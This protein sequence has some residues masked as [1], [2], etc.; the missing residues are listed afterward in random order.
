MPFPP[1]ALHAADA[2]NGHPGRSVS[3]TSEIGII[4]LGGLHSSHP[5]ME[6]ETH[7]VNHRTWR[8]LSR[9]VGERCKTQQLSLF[10]QLAGDDELR[11]LGESRSSAIRSVTVINQSSYERLRSKP[12]GPWL[13]G[14]WAVAHPVTVSLDQCKAM[15][16]QA[17]RKREL[18]QSAYWTSSRVIKGVKTVHL[19]DVEE[20]QRSADEIHATHAADR[21]EAEYVDKSSF[22]PGGGNA[23]GR[24]GYTDAQR[25]RAVKVLGEA[26]EARKS[27]EK[28]IPVIP[29]D[30]EL[31]RTVRESMAELFERR[32]DHPQIDERDFGAVMAEIRDNS[33]NTKH[34]Q[35]GTL[36]LH[37]AAWEELF[38]CCH[39]FGLQTVGLDAQGH[40]RTQRKAL[41]ML[42]N[43]PKYERRHIKDGEHGR[44]RATFLKKRSIV[45]ESYI[46]GVGMT[47]AEA[48]RILAD[49]HSPD[50]NMPNRASCYDT[51]FTLRG[52][53]YDNFED[54]LKGLVKM[55]MAGAIIPWDQAPESI[56]RGRARPPRSCAMSLARRER[57]AKARL[58]SDEMGENLWMK[59]LPMRMDTMMDILSFVQH[60]ERDG[61]RVVVAISDEA[62]CYW[63]NESHD[64]DLLC[65]AFEI[66]GMYFICI[67]QPFGAKQAGH[68]S[69]FI[70]DERE[71]PL[72]LMGY[73]MGKFVDDACKPRKSPGH[74]LWVDRLYFRIMAA[75]GVYYGWGNTIYDPITSLPTYDKVIL[76]ASRVAAY[77]GFLLDLDA[78]TLSIS[79]DKL[80][81]ILQFFG[82]VIA[83][84]APGPLPPRI[85][86]KVGGTMVA[87]TPAF[88]IA[89]EL[90]GMCSLALQELISWDEALGQPADAY[91]AM[92][93]FIKHGRALNGLRFAAPYKT[94]LLQGDYS[95]QGV[96]AYIEHGASLI[97]ELQDGDGHP[98]F[99][100]PPFEVP[101]GHRAPNADDLIIVGAHTAAD[102][103]QVDR[104]DM[105]SATGELIT[106]D[107]AVDVL[108]AVLPPSAL[109]GINLLYLC[110][111]QAAAGAWAKGRS[112]SPELHKIVTRLSLKLAYASMRL[113]LQ[114]ASRETPG[115]RS[116]D[117]LGKHVDNSAWHL[118]KDALVMQIEAEC[119]RR[120]RF[121]R[122]PSLD[123]AASDENFLYPI[124]ISRFF[125]PGDPDCVPPVPASSAVDFR[126]Q[127]QWIAK[128]VDPAT[129]RVRLSIWNLPFCLI[130]DGLRIIIEYAL[131]VVFIYPMWPRP[132]MQLLLSLPGAEHSVKL[133]EYG[134]KLFSRGR[135]NAPN[136]MDSQRKWGAAF[137][138][139]NWSDE[140]RAMRTAERLQR[141]GSPNAPDIQPD[142]L[143]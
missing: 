120:E 135:R 49:P 97:A 34:F 91:E 61:Y 117:W 129:D 89:R 53:V 25:E 9:K 101:A 109:R 73:P 14:I 92:Q 19:P 58:C 39:D 88:P 68:I 24:R 130:P 13:E 28:N 1:A 126:R 96:A 12:W 32:L 47:E 75:C 111:A 102:Q 127:G 118:C 100:S 142:R 124:Y 29:S 76:L 119:E 43:K 54:T 107:R 114:W 21:A 11:Q 4:R 140:Q 143:A 84:Y 15:V 27:E 35:P 122:I 141:W 18:S 16:L 52:V 17:A 30:R 48:D 45:R 104:G 36:R 79:E 83:T 82:E 67:V 136:N 3:V 8:D 51:E 106:T 70:G 112:P 42:A 2:V 131:D 66:C 81:F 50:V 7:C 80:N 137:I 33:L 59:D 113:E 134:G 64:D 133:N 60:L 69:V 77:I 74:S 139:V 94:I 38:T 26:L 57:D 78:R 65:H 116:V 10:M 108:I 99:I 105:A 87:I 98:C 56:R 40:T 55:I 41:K 123:V 90:A 93:M 71:R 121:A 5:Q 44:K 20:D 62:N 103:L 125:C 115:G 22:V 31:R 46:K 72:R 23:R 6:A 138:I 110:D 95:P 132:W 86:A 37:I 63:H 85:A 128:L